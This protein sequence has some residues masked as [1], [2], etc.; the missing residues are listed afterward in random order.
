[1]KNGVPSVHPLGGEEIRALRRLRR[2]EPV[3]RHVFQSEREAP[4]TPAGFRKTLARIGEAS[5]LAFLVH[6]H[7][8][9]HACGFKLANEG[10]DTRALRHYLGHRNIQH[11]IRYT[12]LAAGRFDGFWRN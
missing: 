9:R 2:E 7:M 6:P 11:T 5:V 10:Q 8:L 4:M 1:M 3:G 12:E